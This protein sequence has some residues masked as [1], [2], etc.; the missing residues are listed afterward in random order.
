MV[1]PNFSI[2][3]NT[4]L[5]PKL[6]TYTKRPPIQHL[7]EGDFQVALETVKREHRGVQLAIAKAE[8]QRDYHVLDQ[9]LIEVGIAEVGVKI[10]QEDFAIAVNSLIQKGFQAAMAFDKAAAA[11]FEWRLHQETISN[12]LAAME[13]KADAADEG[14]IQE[15]EILKLRGL[16]SKF[17]NYADAGVGDVAAR[18]LRRAMNRATAV[19]RT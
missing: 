15:Q 10:A 1:T 19:G 8:L 11:P 16:V 6:K 4:N 9:R 5:V 13:M 7:T 17:A 14:N 18:S 3:P 2:K 12:K